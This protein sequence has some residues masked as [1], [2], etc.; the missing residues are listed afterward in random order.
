[1][2]A[3]SGL[4]AGSAGV[5]AGGLPVFAPDLAKRT[6][7]G[8][9]WPAPAAGK[10]LARLA[11]ATT[12]ERQAVRWNYALA[13]LAVGR[14]AEALGALET[15]AADEPDLALVGTFQLARGRALVELG[16]DG[17]A[18]VALG[19]PELARNPE[20]C[21][22]RLQALGGAGAAGSALQQL[23]CAKPALV[24]R[25]AAERTPF[26]LAAGKAALA[27]GRADAALHYLQFAPQADPAVVLV[28]AEALRA[29]GEAE[30]ALRPFAQVHGRGDPQQRAAAELGLIEAGLDARRLAPAAALKRL[31]ELEFRWRGDAVERSAL[32]RSFDLARASGQ[33]PAALRAAAALVRYH[34]AAGGLS[35]VLGQAQA[36]LARML[37]PRSGISLT[38]AAGV[39]W[40]YR[41]LAP[42][43]VEGDALVWNLA[44]RLQ[45]AQL[46]ARAAELLEH[47]LTERAHD[48]A[49]GPLSVRVARLRILSGQPDKALEALQSSSRIIYPA[50][51]LADRQRVEAVALQQLGRGGEA[52]AV[53][54]AVPGSGALQ[55]ELLWKQRSWGAL[56]DLNGR[57]LPLRGALTEVRQA[58]V[59]RQAIT[60]GMLGREGGLAT[61]RG[62]YLAAFTGLPT[63]RAFELLTR[64]AASIDAAALSEALAAMPTVSPAG[65][66]GDLLD[67]APPPPPPATGRN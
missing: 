52:L 30:R 7:V 43:G 62:R 3:A 15:M 55:A 35:P 9:A 26:L 31:S 45:E 36:L 57:N 23:P 60:L 13:M 2:A 53:L 19:Q 66:F 56:A 65:D 12:H 67:A 22:W 44:E 20:A 64:P 40:D 48:V 49:Q 1:M 42:G 18:A 33:A 63:K 46:Y 47:Q 61:L 50:A 41:D 54:Q 37:D 14:A 5:A 6:I 8:P 24:A 16:R 10:V 58:M 38:E 17:D 32:L 39:Y 25:P 59:L 27:A 28:Q 51:M 11:T 29:S 4:A 34:V 21:A